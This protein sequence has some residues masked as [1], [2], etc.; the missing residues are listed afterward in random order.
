MS[1][2]PEELPDWLESN[3][4][5]ILE[6]IRPSLGMK[7]IRSFR[8][9]QLGEGEKHVNILVVANGRRLVFRLSPR[10]IPGTTPAQEFERLPLL[11]KGLGPTP[12]Y[13]DDSRQILPYPVAVLSYVPGKFVATWSERQFR[14][15]A[16]KL[17][18]LHARRHTYGE[19]GVGIE[20]PFFDLRN[21]YRDVME[22]HQKF[23]DANPEL[24]A[25]GRD[26]GAYVNDHAVLFTALDCFSLIHGDLYINNILFTDDDVNYIDWEWMRVGDNAEDLARFYG[27]G[28]GFQP[29]Y[30]PI[31]PQALDVFL[32]TY[33]EE[34]DDPT[35]SKRVEVLNLYFHFA[36][37]MYFLNRLDGSSPQ[38]LPLPR[39][40]YVECIELLTRWLSKALH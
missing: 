22:E 34:L 6:Q 1:A 18:R 3:L 26:V 24:A 9:S 33:R 10:E 15:H 2:L 31:T 12:L 27:L 21:L 5:T 37:L 32:D 25:L 23:L 16:M 13:F 38:Q 17:A 8:A 28:F 35:L 7:R 29:W 11:P 30:T 19:S 39:S 4:R 20:R 14:M 40:H 36:D